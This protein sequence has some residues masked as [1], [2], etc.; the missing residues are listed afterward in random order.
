MTPMLRNWLSL[1]LLIVCVPGGWLARGAMPEETLAV[2]AL[3]KMFQDGLY[4]V[5]ERQSA[6]FIRQFPNSELLSE[7]VLIQARSRIQLRRYDDA[8]ALLAEKAGQAGK[9]G[10]EF[11]FWQAEGRL[12]K[13]DLAGAAEA[14]VKVIAAYPE[15][16][17]RLQASY[18][19]AFARSRQGDNGRAINL[20]R[21]PNS[22]FQ[23]GAQARPDDEWARR[24]WLLLAEL[25]LGAKDLAGA[26]ASLDKLGTQSLAPDLGWQRQFLLAQIR[27]AANQW[28]EAL[29]CF[30][31]LWTSLTNNVPLELQAAAALLQGEAQEKLQQPGAALVSYERALAE[32]VPSGQ[33]RAALQRIVTLS[34][35][36]NRSPEILQRLET[37]A[38]QRPQDELLDL[39]R[40]TLGELRLKQFYATRQSPTAPTPESAAAATNLLQQARAQFE[41]VVTNHT[42][43]PLLGRAQLNRGW[44]LWE[45]GTN[46]LPEAL[47]TFRAATEKLL[48]PAPQAIARIKW[49]DCQAQLGDLAGARANYWLV[50]TNYTAVPGLTNSLFSQA[51]FQIVRASIDLNDLPGASAASARLLQLDPSGDFAPRAELLLAQALNRQGN[52]QASRVTY[53]D[54]LKRFT[55]SILVPEVRLAVVHT[56]EQEN[57]L[58]E[59]ITACADWLRAYSNQT[60]VA[61]ALVAQ[62][63]FDLARLSYRASP[64]TNALALLAGFGAQYP[65]STNAPLAQYLIGEYY[66]GQG[67]YGKAELHFLDRSLV[68]NTNSALTELVCRARLMAG[69]AAVARQSYP[70]ARD[71]FY[72]I[73]T[74]GPLAVATSPI[75]VPIVAEA[76][77][78]LGDTFRQEPLAGETNSLARFVEAIKAFSKI[79]EQWPTNE[80][81]PLA[82]GCIGECYL[83]LATQDPKRYD[84]AVDALRKVIESSA[85]PTDRS[86]AEYELG[87]VRHKQ[88]ELRSDNDRV[89][90]ANQALDHYLRVLYGQN[91]RPGEAPDP[92]WVKRAGLAAAELAES[93]KK[94][95]TAIG[96]YQRLLTELPPLR[97]R[98]EKKIE[99][100]QA[101]KA[102]ASGRNQ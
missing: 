61:T 39:V 97:P 50:A 18:H 29:S 4:E 89:A 43:S 62:A 77:L 36:Q 22:A 44:C 52:P 76:Y 83:Q 19:E 56:H 80:F 2:D 75:P 25:Q 5:A 38:A 33:R 37:F 58:K 12:A 42:N 15:S 93:L 53:E 57:A 65:D 85:A 71:H 48:E 45:E 6:D 16:P 74:N 92:L 67:D 96:I 49:A 70:S 35:N 60:T 72:W 24:G 81:A 95:D 9:R 73:I 21:D 87:V 14:F 41:A 13:G 102:K 69:R 47:L 98:F 31:N 32:G 10:D 59:A 100:L 20:L 34:L 28:P 27:A 8:I 64:D 17:L 68:L 55:N 7:A 63:T 26:E 101:A 94:T 90:L 99:E 46:R 1:A 84:L 23:H 79:T 54:F 91:L 78:L 11:A 66:F 86:R 82:W 30:T 3:R 88:S 40:V 51:L